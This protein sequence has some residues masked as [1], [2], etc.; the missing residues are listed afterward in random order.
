MD[1]GSECQELVE[2]GLKGR[3][4]LGFSVELTVELRPRE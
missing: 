2:E 3:A 4:Y 1:V